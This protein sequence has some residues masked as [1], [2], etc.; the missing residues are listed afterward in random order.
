M[1]VN[2]RDSRV[3]H[4]LRGESSWLNHCLR[5]EGASALARHSASSGELEL[6]Q[7]Y[8]SSPVGLGWGYQG[9][10]ASELQGSSGGSP[11]VLGSGPGL[12][13]PFTAPSTAPGLLSEERRYRHGGR[14]F[15]GGGRMKGLVL[16][17]PA[18]FIA[19]LTCDGVRRV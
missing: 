12:Q 15:T 4:L 5:V 11:G 7:P 18:S 2:K 1:C 10:A 14:L 6:E 17:L 13:R 9:G 16:S 19:T 3:D 8:A